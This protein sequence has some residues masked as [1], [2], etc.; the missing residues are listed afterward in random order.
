MAPAQLCWMAVGGSATMASHPD[1]PFPF[2]T[3]RIITWV[4]RNGVYYYTYASA[5]PNHRDGRLPDNGKKSSIP[6]AM[7]ISSIPQIY[8]NV[9]R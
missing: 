3:I 5:Y 8:R 2:R 7:R 1:R 4:D 9:N 6:H